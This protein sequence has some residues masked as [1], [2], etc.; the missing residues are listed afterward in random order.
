[1]RLAKFPFFFLG[2]RRMV[3][4]YLGVSNGVRCLKREGAAGQEGNGQ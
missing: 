2:C 3:A 4:T 1:M